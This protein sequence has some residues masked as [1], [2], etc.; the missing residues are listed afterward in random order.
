MFFHM[1]DFD[2]PH[3]KIYGDWPKQKKVA[4]LKELH[5]IMA[6]Y[7]LRRFASCTNMADYQA[8]AVEQQ[9]ALGNPHNFNAVNC[10]KLIRRWADQN[11]MYEPFLYVFESG[12]G[13][14]ERELRRV[15]NDMTHEQGM[16][17]ELRH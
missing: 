9:F 7:S 10:F 17:I 16:P 14:H 11:K 2:N 12:A 8:L 5:G 3:S 1:T 4:F 13:L 15:T 6:K